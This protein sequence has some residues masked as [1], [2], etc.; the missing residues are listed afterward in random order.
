[1]RARLFS[2]DDLR[3]EQ[4]CGMQRL[5][6]AHFCN[7]SPE[8][9]ERD[10]AEK[11]WVILLEQDDGA[12]AGF[13]TL[14]VYAD[15]VRGEAATIV[16]SGDT[17][18]AREG[19]GSS[20]LSRSWITCVNHLAQ[21]RGGGR[22]YWL[23]I[24]SGFRTYRFLPVFW[25]EFYP[26]WDRPTP[27]DIQTTMDRL[28]LARFGAEYHPALGVVRF[29]APQPLRTELQAIPPGRMDDPHIAFFARRNPGFVDGDELVCLTELSEENLTPCGRRMVE[30]GQ[31]LRGKEI[32]LP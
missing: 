18:V 11:N 21:L 15:C 4:R 3:N 29:S 5:L 19:W 13:T 7:V 30:A 25:K 22:V 23:L 2:R 17:I 1:M 20:A 12:L 26:R 14:L 28:A 31:R 16:Y 6:E 8:R 32:L 24:S 27:L 9:F 10:L